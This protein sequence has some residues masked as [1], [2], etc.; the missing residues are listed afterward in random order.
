MRGSRRFYASAEG[1]SP[2]RLIFPHD[3]ARAGKEEEKMT[4]LVLMK[5]TE[6][7]SSTQTFT[8]E[9]DD[10]YEA[11]DRAEDALLKEYPMA[12]EIESETAKR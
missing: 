6:R 12:E 7:Q 9:A 10:M 5:W 2:R 4:F 3:P 8:V 11:I 1:C